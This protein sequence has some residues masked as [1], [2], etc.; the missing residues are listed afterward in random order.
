MRWLNRS[1]IV[2]W[3]EAMSSASSQSGRISFILVANVNRGVIV[4]L[5]N[6]KPVAKLVNSYA[7]RHVNDLDDD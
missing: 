3:D 1:M 5:A 6:N 2:L 4:S 7:Q